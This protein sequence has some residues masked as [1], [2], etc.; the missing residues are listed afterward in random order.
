MFAFASLSRIGSSAFFASCPKANASARAFSIAPE[1]RR[2]ARPRRTSSSRLRRFAIRRASESTSIE[3]P[4]LRAWIAT[5]VTLPSRRSVPVRFPSRARSPTT[6][7]MSSTIW[8]A[9]PR[10]RPY[11]PT[12]SMSSRR[13]PAMSPMIFAPAMIGKAVFRVMM[14]RYSWCVTAVSK[15]WRFWRISP[16]ARAA[17]ASAGPAAVAP[18]NLTPVPQALTTTKAPR[19]GA[20]CNPKSFYAPPE[21]RRLIYRL[22]RFEFP[23]GGRGPGGGET[24]ADLGEPLLAAGRFACDLDD[25]AGGHG[26]VAGDGLDCRSDRLE[27]RVDHVVAVADPIGHHHDGHHDC[28]ERVDE[29]LVVD[30]RRCEADRLRREVGD[31]AQVSVVVLDREVRVVVLQRRQVAQLLLPHRDQ[32]EVRDPVPEVMMDADDVVHQDH[33]GIVVVPAGHEVLHAAELVRVVREGHVDQVVPARRRNVTAELFPPVHRVV[34]G[35]ERLRDLLHPGDREVRL[36]LE[37]RERLA[38]R[39]PL[40]HDLHLVEVVV[41]MRRVVPQDVEATDDVVN[42]VEERDLLLTQ[43]RHEAL[44]EARRIEVRVE[45]R[46]EDHVVEVLRLQVRVVAFVDQVVQDADDAL[47]ED[48]RRHRP[49]KVLRRHVWE[50]LLRHH[51]C[52]R[53]EAQRLQ[54]VPHL[55]LVFPEGAGRDVRRPERDAFGRGVLLEPLQRR[56]DARDVVLQV[57]LVESEVVVVEQA[58]GVAAEADHGPR[59]EIEVLGVDAEGVVGL[60]WHGIGRDV[61]A[62]PYEGA[63]VDSPI[64]LLLLGIRSWPASW[65]RVR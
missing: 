31:S 61:P 52:P 47:P 8:K 16:S 49:L 45:H 13:A 57:V 62:S 51:R 14:S 21:S 4:S 36:L 10:F 11:S 7:R 23:P 1:S 34:R 48:L 26:P 44:R 42:Q 64:R 56:V 60:D 38:E 37:H 9:I 6:S 20:S 46:A 15:A 25:R 12:A 32:G 35:V 17:P 24:G 63:A 39:H 19:T 41:T 65:N 33:G 2:S 30:V 54:V 5:R 3:L 22:R 29:R 27:E 28:H 55:A 43:H 18:T 53:G 50:I 58:F 40:V 59:E